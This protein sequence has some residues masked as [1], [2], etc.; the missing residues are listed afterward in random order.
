MSALRI[1]VPG[2]PVRIVRDDD[3]ERRLTQRQRDVLAAVRSHRGNRS[4][5]ARDLGVTVQSVQFALRAITR[6]GVRVPR[7]ASRGPDLAPRRRA[8]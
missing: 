8:A 4:R 2:Q 5:A 6:R 1:S 7:G 3:P